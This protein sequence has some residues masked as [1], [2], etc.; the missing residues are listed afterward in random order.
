MPSLCRACGS[1][2]QDN[3]QS[4]PFCGLSLGEVSDYEPPVSASVQF[5]RDQSIIGF[6]LIA[7]G[8][9][10]F[11]GGCGLIFSGSLTRLGSFDSVVTLFLVGGGAAVAAVTAG[12]VMVASRPNSGGAATGIL[13]GLLAGLMA[14]GVC[15]LTV[16]AMIIYALES[17]L[18]GCQ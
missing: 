9:I 2:L 5:E 11:L 10:G 4:C 18:N 14:L 17:C 12:T 3:W 6:G 15:G 13:G 8:V 7:L 1:T 16:L